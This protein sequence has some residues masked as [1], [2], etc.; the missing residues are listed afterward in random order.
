[1][2]R[3]T[4]IIALFTF[5]NSII[6]A[7]DIMVGD[8]YYFCALNGSCYN[9]VP[10]RLVTRVDV[11]FSPEYA[12]FLTQQFL[13]MHSG[14]TIIEPSS[15]LYNCHGYAYSVYQSEIPLQIG[16]KENLCSYNGTSVESYIQIE[17]SQIQ[18]EI[19]QLLLKTTFTHSNR[20]ILQL[21]GI[22]IL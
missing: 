21:Y 10:N 14:C 16:W 5:C 7:Q 9:D 1:M 15:K 11:D 6:C 20:G 4:V 13:L 12:S 18:K 8:P 22:M 19:L 17:E 3:I 2:K